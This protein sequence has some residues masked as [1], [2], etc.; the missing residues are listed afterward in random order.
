MRLRDLAHD[1]ESHTRAWDEAGLLAAIEAFEDARLLMFRYGGAVVA[2]REAHRAVAAG[3]HV[4]GRARRRVLHRV[5]QEL[6]KGQPQEIAVALNHQEVRHLA[7][8]GM[9]V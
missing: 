3:A 5:V 6:A 9:S 4:D 8:D 7:R 1:G 2:H